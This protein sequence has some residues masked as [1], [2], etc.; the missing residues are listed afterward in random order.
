MLK[1]LKTIPISSF[2]LR[3]VLNQS[4]SLVSNSLHA[5]HYS[6]YPHNAFDEMP[7]RISFISH[8]LSLLKQNPTDLLVIASAHSLALK[9]NALADISLRTSLLTSYARACDLDSSLAL[10]NE[11]VSSCDLISWN[12]IIT[13]CVLNSQF[14]LSIDLFKEMIA[15]LGEFDSTTLVIMISGLTRVRNLKHGLM[16]HGFV[17]KRGLQ[18][19]VYLCNALIDMYAKCGE[20]RRSEFVFGEMEVKDATSWNSITNGCLYNDLP[21]K[22]AFFYREMCC[23]DVRPDQMSLSSVISACSC[24]EELSG[25]GES[26]HSWVIKL[27]YEGIAHSSVANSLISF[28]SSCEHVREANKVF[29]GLGTKNT[30][31]WNSMIKCLI[32]NG[33]IDEGLTL[34]F[35]MQSAYKAQPD[36]I[37]LV[38]IIPVCGELNLIHQGKSIHGFSI[39]KG[40]WVSS[41]PVANTLLD[42][43]LKCDNLVSA[44]LLFSRMPSKDLVTWNTMI[45]GYSSSELYAEESKLMF[46]ELLQNGQ[47]CTLATLLA[48]LPSCISPRD[49]TFGKPV[50]CWELKYGFGNIISAVNAL[51]LMY[52]YCGD[53]RASLALLEN[54][55]PASDV[56]SWN[57]IISGYVKN[58]H[59]R[60]ALGAY[61]FM[62]EMLNLDPDP[63]TMSCALSASGNLEFLSYG[64]SLH[65]F[66]LKSPIGSDVRVRNALITMYFRCGDPLSSELVFQPEGDK[67]LCSWSSMICG[68]AQNQDGGKAIEYFHQMKMT[69]IQPNEISLVGLL[70][71]CTHLGNLRF[72][73]EIHGYIVRFGFCDN[74]FIAS[75]LVDMYS[76]CGR[77]EF[78]ERVFESSAE[79]T[80]ASWNSMISAYGFHGQGQKAIEHFSKMSDLGIKATKSTFIAILSAC[81]HC[82]LIDEGWKHYKLM[83]EEFDLEGT[84]EH[85]VLMVDM[86]GKAG[87]IHEAYEFV[88]E[89]GSKAESEVWGAL[90]SACRDKGDIDMGKLIAEKLFSLESENSGYYVALSNLYAYHGMWNCAEDIRSMI[91]D[92]RL[93]KLPGISLVEAPKT[94]SGEVLELS[95]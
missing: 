86:L 27:G 71:A 55:L 59:Y 64:Q 85:R 30:I 31:S 91:R 58:G 81:S 67:N 8:P 37:T 93:M 23:S 61:K 73:R 20:L 13:A 84:I 14:D 29:K 19:N 60:D 80:T 68:F 83:V 74:I 90:L 25:F 42:M 21:V 95:I 18:G 43:Y 88:K 16:L 53:L 24:L 5:L 65:G 72:G 57:T 77:L 12:A 11:S 92:R 45:S 78:S 94:I 70:C 10:F 26:V 38:T 33:R 17:V 63:I 56:V 44:E 51:M 50:H 82:G 2:P 4:S 7:Q 62:Y 32:E 28:Y 79:K 52:I 87:R 76:K 39:R 3:S 49:L 22:S 48:I 15:G 69:S 46:R 6:Q 89:M 66:V 75:A 1:S 41:L 9:T 34:F 54:I 36:A 47:R 35:S 40:I